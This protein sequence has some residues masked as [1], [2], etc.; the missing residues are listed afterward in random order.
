MKFSKSLS[1]GSSSRRPDP[2]EIPLCTRFPHLGDIR[3]AARGWLSLMGSIPIRRLVLG[4]TLKGFCRLPL[5]QT[6]ERCVFA[7]NPSFLPITWAP[8]TLV[9]LKNPLLI[10]TKPEKHTP[11]HWHVVVSVSGKKVLLLPLSTKPL[12]QYLELPQR[13]SSFSL[14][15]DPLTDS[16]TCPNHLKWW[17]VDT[18]FLQTGRDSQLLSESE[19]ESC[20]DCL[21]DDLFLNLPEGQQPWWVKPKQIVYKQSGL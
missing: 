2:P 12:S 14:K 17:S 21:Y 15:C 5:Y 4:M 8:G 19:F 13:S 6:A 10:R 16:F 20:L 11:L 7:F 9:K 3:V 1:G 18:P